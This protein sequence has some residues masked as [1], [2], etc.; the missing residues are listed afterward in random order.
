[1][2]EIYRNYKMIK[3][4]FGQIGILKLRIRI[5]TF[6]GHAGSGSVCIEYESATLCLCVSSL[7]QNARLE[8]L[9]VVTNEKGEAVGEVVTIIC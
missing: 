1:M 4:F 6:F 8:N 7:P 3:I 9:K 5:Q 2:V